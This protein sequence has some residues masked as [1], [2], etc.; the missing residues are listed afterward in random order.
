MAALLTVV[1]A[2]ALLWAGALLVRWAA[3]YL[4]FRR[5]EQAIPGPKSLPVLGNLLDLAK[6]GEDD[7]LT[8][9]LSIAGG[10]TELSR[11]S[12]GTRMMVV[13]SDPDHVAV[14]L[15][16]PRFADKSDVFYNYL[17]KVCGPGL[18]TTNGGHWKRHRAVIRPAFHPSVIDEYV[19]VFAEEAEALT[20]AL[21]TATADGGPAP[22]GV[23]HAGLLQSA[24]TRALTRASLRTVMA[25]DVHEDDEPDL[26]VII[27]EMGGRLRDVNER[28][29]R[30]WLWPDAAFAVSS[31]G[32]RLGSFNKVCADLG[33][34]ILG[35][36]RGRLHSGE[37]Q[38]VSLDGVSS[39][40]RTFAEILAESEFTDAEILT[41]GKTLF[42][43]S[44]ETNVTTIKFVLK[45]LSVKPDIQD[46]VHRELRSVLGDDMSL[47]ADQVNS[48]PY[49]EAVVLETLRLLPSF[50]LMAR[51]V[52]EETQLGGRTLP[53]DAMLLIN[54]FGLHR[55]PGSFPD[56]LRFEPGRFLA[57]AAAG[58]RHPYSFIPFS[59]GPR[60][61]IGKR[62][63]MHAVKT[64]LAAV[65]RAF[66]V[67]PVDD[68][69]LEPAEFPVTFHLALHMVGGVSVKLTPRDR[70]RGSI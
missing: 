23:L 45:V 67:D 25:A 2:T 46:R 63:G 62:Y 21:R 15:R 50:P 16:D 57:E 19:P 31:M 14:V 41:E 11:A 70:S 33:G 28:M 7:R 59:A 10:R 39:K 51:T 37:V 5:L 17:E 40:R 36:I 24:L 35:R 1:A 3:R 53:A 61:C 54:V 66:R 30:P 38:T 26:E 55:D 47:T 6:V 43:A 18:L 34:R 29:F 32:K 69:H 42:G 13:V 52:R 9:L 8:A 56:P 60:S 27:R 44:V 20:V 58:E 48:L 64:V 68:G 12:V 22:D 4:H 49:L 65:L